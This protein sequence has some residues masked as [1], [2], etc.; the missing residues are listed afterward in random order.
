V[1]SELDGLDFMN[2]LWVRAQLLRLY[3]MAMG[4]EPVPFISPAGQEAEGRKFDGNL[5][6]KII[7]YVA[8]K[9]Q[10]A[11]SVN[12]NINNIGRL[13]DADLEKIAAQGAGRV[14]SEQ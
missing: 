8:P 10:K 3:P 7:E 9:T 5:A 13:S 11:P 1:Q 12:I 6:M 14:V 4:D 2:D